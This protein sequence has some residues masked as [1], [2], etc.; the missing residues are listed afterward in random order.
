[1]MTSKTAI[2]RLTSTFE[3]DWHTAH[4]YEAPD[5]L[6]SHAHVEDDFPHD[7]DLVHE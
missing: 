5:P 4:N 7:P 2:H 1:V 6:V 3:A